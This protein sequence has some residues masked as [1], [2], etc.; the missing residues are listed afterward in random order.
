VGVS[1]IL[2]MIDYSSPGP[3]TTLRPDQLH[4]TE[5]LPPDPRGICKA[6]QGLVIQPPDATAAGIADER[7]P[8]R[9]LRSAAA[10]VDALMAVDPR[11]LDAP[12][13]AD[14]RVVGTCRHFATLATAL[15]RLR[16][17]PARARCGFGTYFWSGRNLDHWIVEYQPTEETVVGQASRVERWV[18]IDVE[19]LDRDWPATLDDLRPGEFLTGGEAWR[20][21]R[22]GEV[23][24][25]LFGVPGTDHAWGPGE[26]RGNAIRDLASLNK[27]EMLPWDEWG[28][29][30]DSYQGRTGPDYDLLMD[31]VADPGDL[32]SLYLKEDLAVPEEMVN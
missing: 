8:E 25:M 6:V 9:N 14:R 30:D 28:R 19:H 26:I 22:T 13:T 16:G 2:D 32:E 12:R 4:L 29:M 31:E 27:L 5:R 15:L 24:G 18:R 11:P 1:S 20:W 23:D 7:L 21:Y 3:L 10:L 17:I